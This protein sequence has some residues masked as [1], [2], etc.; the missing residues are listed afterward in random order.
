MKTGENTKIYP[1]LFLGLFILFLI[2]FGCSRM[3]PDGPEKLNDV[4]VTASL[5]MPHRGLSA[6]MITKILLEITGTDFKTI[7]KELTLTGTKAKTS[8]KVPADKKLT[9]KATAF[10]DTIAVLQGQADVKAKG[11]DQVSLPIKLDFLVPAMILTPPDAVIKAGDTLTVYLEA[12]A[13]SDLSTIGARIKFEQT[14]LD[15]IDLVREDDFLKKNGG[16]VNQLPIPTDD[17]QGIMD[18][19]LGVF[20]ASTA[21]SGSGKILRIVFKATQAD[22][23]D[24][25]I[26]LD[27]A[28]NSDLGLFDKNANLM[29]SL[30]LGNRIIIHQ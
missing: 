5:Q 4:A 30:A 16:S 14:S 11:G 23:A 2:F 9:F 19:V 27:N 7:E 13:V 1:P 24:L 29:Y 26:T 10:Q 8:I 3:F 28:F 18:V 25:T 6:E 21:V 22:T 15:I 12:R 20:P 17:N